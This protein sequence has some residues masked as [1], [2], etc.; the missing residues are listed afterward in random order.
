M[1]MDSIEKITIIGNR[2]RCKN[3]QY[4]WI[5]KGKNYWYATCPRCLHK[6]NI[7][8]SL[9]DKPEVIEHIV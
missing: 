8:K 6:V 2:L 4:I 3:C 9:L 7:N 5:Y 1:G